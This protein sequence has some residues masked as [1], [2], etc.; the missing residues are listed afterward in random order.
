MHQ[1]DYFQV[2]LGKGQE[3]RAIVS[4]RKSAF[5]VSNPHGQNDTQTFSLTI[6][7]QDLA[8]VARETTD[9]PGQPVAPIA[10]KA[11]WQAPADMVAYVAVA[12]STPHDQ[13]GHL[14]DVYPEN[15]KVAPAPYTLTIRVA[16]GD[17][18][19]V[20]AMASP[21]RLPIKPGNGFAESGDLSVPCMVA[22]DIK[23]REVQFY[24]VL[25]KQGESLRLALGAQKPYYRITNPGFDE[26]HKATFTLTVYD[27]DQVQV[28]QRSLDILSVPPDARSTGLAWR[29]KSKG[30]C[31]IAVSFD[32]TGHD[33]YVYRHG[34]PPGPA[35]Y[36]IQISTAGQD[37]G[38]AEEHSR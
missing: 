38:S 29:S 15:A 14:S 3:L 9:V 11:T 35:R 34:Q 6:Y 19:P 1:A 36:A 22:A 8:M 4:L 12:A 27:D 32:N 30:A 23:F 13:R 26:D 16:G 5:R 18:G 17:R 33:V 25:A 2:P 31:Y 21:A 24:K 37:K 28:D 7:D 20:Q 10:W